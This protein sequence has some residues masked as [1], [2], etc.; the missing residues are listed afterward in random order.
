MEKAGK[1]RAN[2]SH[3]LIWGARVHTALPFTH[4]TTH[5]DYPPV[6]LTPHWKLEVEQTQRISRWMACI[7]AVD[8]PDGVTAA[9]RRNIHDAYMSGGTNVLVW[10]IENDWANPDYP[11]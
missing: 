5:M 4:G 3:S 11:A 1:S 10:I 2:S 6:S 7:N 8:L 9:Q